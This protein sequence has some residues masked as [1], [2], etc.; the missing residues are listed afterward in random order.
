LARTTVRGKKATET[1]KTLRTGVIAVDNGGHKTKVFT[2]DME[3]P[4]EF[5]SKKGRASKLKFDVH[6]FSEFEDGHH[7]IYNG[8]EYY[9]GDMEVLC[10]SK[11]NPY[12][13]SK[14]TEYFI[15]SIIQAVALYG[16]DRNYVL[17]CVPFITYTEEEIS[18]IVNQLANKEHT[19]II[20][21][22]ERTFE[23]LDVQVVPE[24]TLASWAIETQGKTRWLDLGSRT[25]GFSTTINNNGMIIPLEK[26][27]G[28]I[29]KQGL[30]ITKL[31]DNEESYQEYVENASIE[32]NRTWNEDDFIIAFG[33][34]ALR[35]GLIKA[36]QKVY[37][38]LEVAEDPQFVQVIGL[39]NFGLALF[40]DGEDNE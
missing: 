18:K 13:D 40:G 24:S 32:L 17:T 39:L 33:G 25:I 16:Y 15:I 7:I 34:G 30:E 28:T 4:I 27:S 29:N 10:V 3:S 23:I 36:F 37:P 22:I 6:N 26:E 11:L 12:T 31:P 2:P 5:L 20:D 38:N 9:T 14:A 8:K 19:A 1:T 35:E 21:G